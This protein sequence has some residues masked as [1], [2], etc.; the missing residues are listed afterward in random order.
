MTIAYEPDVTTARREIE[1]RIGVA[2]IEDLLAELA[3]TEEEWSQLYGQHGPGGAF[4]AYRKAYR[5]VIACEIRDAAATAGRKVTE[6]EV[7]D[8]ACAHPKYQR[9][10]DQAIID[11][12][13]FAAL[14]ARRASV[15][16]RVRRDNRLVDFRSREP[17]GGA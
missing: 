7:E 12:A 10:L 9:L 14:D 4:D 17:H 3:A 5:A 8:R 11:R 16:E 13:R 1:G 15:M 6:S 2:P